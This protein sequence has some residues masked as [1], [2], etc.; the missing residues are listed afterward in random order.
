MKDEAPCPLE[1]TIRPP[2]RVFPT[3]TLTSVTLVQ[4]DLPDLVAFRVQRILNVDLRR[5]VR[6]GAE[7]HGAV[8]PVKREIRH[9]DGETDGGGGRG[10][11]KFSQ[12]MNGKR[13]KSL[14]VCVYVCVLVLT[15][16]PQALQYSAGGVQVT[17]PLL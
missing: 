13:R 6:V 10:A 12:K 14:S 2:S 7:L 1:C 5:V 4:L 15:L 16:T 8:L 11:G 17:L 9:L 3:L